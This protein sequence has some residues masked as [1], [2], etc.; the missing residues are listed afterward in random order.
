MKTAFYQIAFSVVLVVLVVYVVGDAVDHA[1]SGLSAA[2][3][4][5]GQPK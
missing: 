4:V 2:L 5:A 3:S 1:F